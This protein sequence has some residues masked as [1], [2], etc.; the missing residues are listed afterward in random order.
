MLD[1]RQLQVLQAVARAGSLAAAAR[2]LHYS[3]PTVAHHLQALEAHLGVTLVERTT[4][5][6]TLTDLGLLFLDHVDAVLDRLGSAESEV[7]ALARHGV[8]TLRIGTF[9]TAGAHV[10]PPAVASVQRSTGVRIE[11]V[12]AEPPLLLARLASRELHA[13]LIYDDPQHP[14]HLVDELAVVTLFDDP[15]LLVLPEDHAWAGADE[16]PLSGLADEGWILSHDISEPGDQAL[17]AACATEGFLPRPMLRTDDY[18][19]IFGFVAAGVGIA[20][21]PQMALVRREGIVVRPLSGV[22]LARS[23]RFVI[24]RE[25]APPAVAPLLRALQSQLSTGRRQA[26]LVAGPA[27]R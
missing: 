5:G 14:I 3:Q 6:S 21:V 7:K 9:P 20:L 10:L 23:V 22:Q 2:E 24:H 4:R 25:G 13:A 27:A 15:F 16:V 12:E 17:R 1:L 19:V 11:L 26:T 18:D 8:A